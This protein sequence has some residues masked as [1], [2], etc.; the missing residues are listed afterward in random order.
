MVYHLALLILF[1]L[2]FNVRC[3]SCFSHA[4]H[5]DNDEDGKGAGGEA[6]P[7]IL[8]VAVAPE[9]AMADAAPRGSKGV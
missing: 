5:R 7:S 6:G 1:Q 8:Q 9:A 2:C 4:A 3:L